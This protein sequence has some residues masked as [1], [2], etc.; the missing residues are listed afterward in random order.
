MNNKS[1]FLITIFAS[2]IAAVGGAFFQKKFLT[3]KPSL[4][5]ETRPK[6]IIIDKAGDIIG[7]KIYSE[8]TQ[9]DQLAKYTFTLKNNGD[10]IFS[11]EAFR[12][13]PIMIQFLA[14]IMGIRVEDSIP[15]ILLWDL[16]LDEQGKLLNIQPLDR[17]NPNSSIT[18]SIFLSEQLIDKPYII[19]DT[20]LEGVIKIKETH[21]DAYEKIE[22]RNAFVIFIIITYG[23]FLVFNLVFYFFV[24]RI[25]KSAA[26]ISQ[27]VSSSGIEKIRKLA[28]IYS[29]GPV[30]SSGELLCLIKESIN[31]HISDIVT[32]VNDDFYKGLEKLATTVKYIT[33]FF[34]ILHI[35]AILTGLM[36][37]KPF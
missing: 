35:I 9:L 28:D 27:N 11:K 36:L 23:I 18:F 25:F 37:F 16:T 30:E 1:T 3:D 32:F 20:N 14:P 7:L 19:K 5:I 33:I 29:N 15:S 22:R 8:N 24:R 6:E 21:L 13:H 34:L 12:Q 26:Q 4:E 2:I 17:F 10:T 31:T